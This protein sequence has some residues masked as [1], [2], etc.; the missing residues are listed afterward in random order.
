[1]L[2]KI[3]RILSFAYCNILSVGLGGVG[4]RTAARLATFM[5][6]M[7]RHEPA[8]D[9]TRMDWLEYIREVLKSTAV[10]NQNG[11]LLL[12]ELHFTSP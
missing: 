10:H 6:D 2:C 4:F 11:V 9:I 7:T 5:Q 1:M 3:N 12:N 8:T